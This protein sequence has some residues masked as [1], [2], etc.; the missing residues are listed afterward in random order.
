MKVV[1][2]NG[3]PRKEGN[4]TML[5]KHV[6]FELEKEGIETELV[7]LA[8]K[9]I[10]GCLS[11]F[12]CFTNQDQKCSVKND[13]FNECL[14][15]MAEADGII[16]ASPT[17]VS[18]VTAEIKALIDRACMVVLG[19]GNTM[20]KRK[21]GASVVAARRAGSMMAFNTLNQFFMISQMIVP[22]AKYWNIGIGLMPGDVE[23][24]EEGKSIMQSLG[25]NMAWLLKKIAS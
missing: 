11:C 21:V 16:L 19:N 1:A 4:T 2:I 22:A 10:H 14:A 23:K 12:K 3:S 13:D 8:G 17:Y 6:F 20:L 15:K 7:Q 5:V 9:K 24:D 25:E 18:S